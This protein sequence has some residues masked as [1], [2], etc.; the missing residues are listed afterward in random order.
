MDRTCNSLLKCIKTKQPSG[1]Q[2]LDVRAELLLFEDVHFRHVQAE[3]S[4]RRRS[5]S[6]GNKV[7][8]RK[9]RTGRQMKKERETLPVSQN[10]AEAAG[11]GRS[12]K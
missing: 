4:D 12:N 11:S 7:S 5:G 6:A 8:K 3:Q 1:S 9:R 10:S 2:T